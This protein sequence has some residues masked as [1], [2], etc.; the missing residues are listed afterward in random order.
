MRLLQ[1]ALPMASNSHCHQ[2][3]EYREHTMYKMRIK[4]FRTVVRE[5]LKLAA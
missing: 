2:I 4:D 1:M 3:L 5:V